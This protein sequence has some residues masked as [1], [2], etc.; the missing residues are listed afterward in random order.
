M[1]IIKRWFRKL[2]RV[3]CPICQSLEGEV[4]WLLKEVDGRF[5]YVR[6]HYCK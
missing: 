4:G 3:R 6:C 2:F 5:V 1:E